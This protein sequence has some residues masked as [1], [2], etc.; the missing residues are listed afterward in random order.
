MNLLEALN[1]V[2]EQDVA[3]TIYKLCHIKD[4]DDNDAPSYCFLHEITDI[5]GITDDEALNIARKYGYNI[6]KVFSNE[7]IDGSLLVADKE[8]SIDQIKD[9]YIKFFGVEVEIEKLKDEE[10][11]SGPKYESLKESMSGTTPIQDIRI[12]NLINQC[13]EDV[14]SLY[15]DLSFDNIYYMTGSST[16]TFGT[17]CY[18]DYENGNFTL[19]LNK[20]MFNEDDNAIKN[21]IY[22]ELAHYVQMSWQFEYDIVY[23]EFGQL[24]GSYKYRTK[25]WQS[26]GT[27]WR[28][29]AD[30]IESHFNVK[31]SSTDSYSTHTGVGDYAQEQ[32]KWVVKCNHCGR[33]FKYEKATPFVKEPNITHYDYM[34]KY[35]KE[36]DY[37]KNYYE[38]HPDIKKERQNNLYWRCGCGVKGEFETNYDKK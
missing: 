33:E 3:K 30:N 1:D 29:I 19:V 13:C 11:P 10:K 32:K 9:D 14:K 28:E 5:Y 31:I 26:H 37:Y 8:C 24:R 17:M 35:K 22:H 7:E 34:I 15:P 38:Q 20:H 4:V 6:I 36:K 21:T 23:W 27:V 16:H 2:N 12:I 18:P 25:E